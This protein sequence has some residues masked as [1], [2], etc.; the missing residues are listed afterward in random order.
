M[1]DCRRAVQ[2]R[3]CRP[4]PATTPG[5]QCRT[6]ARPGRQK[7]RHAR[8]F[9]RF[10]ARG[11]PAC[12]GWEPR[13]PPRARAVPG[14]APVVGGSPI[15]PL[16]RAARGNFV[17]EMFRGARMRAI[18]YTI[19]TIYHLVGL[20]N[21]DAA[22]RTTSGAVSDGRRPRCHGAEHRG[23]GRTHRALREDLGLT[24]QEMAD[25]TGRTLAEYAAAGVGRARPVV[26]LPVQVR[27]AAGR[28]RDRASDGRGAALEGLHAHARGR[29]AVH[30]APRRFE[31]LHKAPHSATS[32]PS[33]SW[34]RRRIWKRSRTRPSTCPTTRARTRLHHIA[35]AC[36]SP[37]RAHVE[38]L[39][40]GDLLMYDSGRGA[41]HDRHGRRALRVSG[42]GHEAA[43]GGHYLGASRPSPAIRPG[44][45]LPPHAGRR[46]RAAGERGGVRRKG[47]RARSARR[48]SDTCPHPPRGAGAAP[49]SK[50]SHHEEHPPALRAREEYDGEGLLTG[51]SVECPPDF[52]FGYDVVDDIAE[53]DPRPPRHGVVQPRGRSTCSPSPT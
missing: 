32:W 20:S 4:F 52:N 42:R 17:S 46:Q 34:S 29:R 18:D 10:A 37:T 3:P 49:H 30:Q 25:A 26:H 12:V 28:G 27:R 1:G 36:A 35:A 44:A 19:C 31:Y 47:C 15:R 23:G 45:A 22:S 53:N 5:A 13:L 8:A 9:W 51:F 21:R 2:H 14:L 7:R 43:R 41:R 16:Q 40:A 48:P 50:G 33:R 24:M 38:E 6:P 39:E 11:A